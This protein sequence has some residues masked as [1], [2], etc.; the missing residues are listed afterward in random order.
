MHICSYRFCN[1]G[2]SVTG[3]GNCFRWC[4]GSNPDRHRWRIH[5][6]IIIMVRVDCRRSDRHASPN[7]LRTHI[8]TDTYIRC[9]EFKNVLLPT[10]VLYFIGYV[11]V[12]EHNLPENWL[13]MSKYKFLWSKDNIWGAVTCFWIR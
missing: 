9:L 2:G 8:Q 13:M 11:A 12:H 10:H 7:W 1:C 4:A 3:R 6:Q 5:P